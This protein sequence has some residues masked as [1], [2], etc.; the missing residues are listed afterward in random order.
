MNGTYH[1][2]AYYRDQ[3]KLSDYQISQLTGVTRS[4]ISDWKHGRHQPQ[5]KTLKKIADFLGIEVNA[6]YN[7]V[8]DFIAYPDEPSKSMILESN[9]VRP[10]ALYSRTTMYGVRLAGGKYIELSRECYEDLQSAIDIFIESWLK[11]KKLI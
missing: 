5:T 3:K 2:Y 11:S 1:N 9:P 7:T 8:P 4:T 10:E 6:F